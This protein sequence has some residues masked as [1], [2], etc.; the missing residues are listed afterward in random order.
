MDVF[1]TIIRPLVTEKS[2]RG[3]TF[4]NEKRGGEYAFEVDPRAN[5]HE[6]RNAIEQIYGV[7][8]VDVRTQVRQPRVRRYRL[9]YGM[10]KG[11]KKAIVV[12]DKDSTI[13]LF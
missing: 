10:T 13:E 1:K 7:R 6:I 4:R 9:N 12:V 8:V 5:K 2:A 11:M 3:A